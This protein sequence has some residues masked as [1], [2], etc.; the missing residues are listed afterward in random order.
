ME[1]ELC[2]ALDW[3]LTHQD[4][5]YE[6]RRDAAAIRS[7]IALPIQDAQRGLDIVDCSY[8]QAVQGATILRQQ[9]AG[10]PAIS[11]AQP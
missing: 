3:T 4:L 6:S 5:M 9:R 8:S 2:L 1:R 7:V 11:L 10:N